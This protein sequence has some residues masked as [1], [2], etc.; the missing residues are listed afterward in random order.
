MPVIP[1]PNKI[2]CECSDDPVKNLSS[3]D[4]DVDRFIGIYDFRLTDVPLNDKFKQ[5]ACKEYCY[6]E[7]SQ[8]EADDCARRRA[9][10]CVYDDVFPPPGPFNGLPVNLFYNSVQTYTVNCPD[11]TP[12]T[13]TIP[14][15]EFVSLSQRSANAIAQSVAKNRAIEHRICILSSAL[16]GGCR[17]SSLSATIQAV[18][19]TALYFPYILGTQ[20]PIG[21]IG[22]GQNFAPIRYIWTL[23]SGSLPP[24]MELDDCTGIISGVPTAT[25]NYTF[26]VRATDAIGSFQQKSLS[27]CIIRITTPAT[28]PDATED[29]PYLVNLTEAPGAQESELW[30]IAYGSLPAGMTLSPAG[31]IS[32]TPVETGD[33]TIGIRV[34]VGSC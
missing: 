7:V 4:A 31:V 17:D 24:G 5:W 1:C 14:A 9:M 23:V 8:E 26:T 10:E 30:T 29:D 3:E 20:T 12:F 25:G 22:C 2:T 28:L 21:F 33:F 19:G 34:S 13:W 16:A 6:S 18:G 32:G 27:I 15:G 11:G